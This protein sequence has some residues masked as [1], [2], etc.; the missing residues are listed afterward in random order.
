MYLRNVT[1]NLP[2]SQLIFV[3]RIMVRRDGGLC[4]RIMVG[5]GGG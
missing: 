1:K 3:E 5:G 2:P 4:W